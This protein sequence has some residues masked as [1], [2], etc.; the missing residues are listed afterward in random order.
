VY[1]TPTEHGTYTILVEAS[2]NG[3]IISKTVNLII[4]DNTEVPIINVDVDN[5]ILIADEYNTIAVS[6]DSN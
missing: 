6:V 4:K 5:G 3:S 2:I 1:I